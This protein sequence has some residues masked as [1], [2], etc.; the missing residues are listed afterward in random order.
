MT[1]E[2]K[3]IP[4]EVIVMIVCR[5]PK[6]K[7]LQNFAMACKTHKLVLTSKA[8]NTLYYESFW[9]PLGVSRFNNQRFSLGALFM[10]SG[11][12][13]YC[14]ACCTKGDLRVQLFGHWR[15]PDEFVCRECEKKVSRYMTVPAECL[16]IGQRRGRRQVFKVTPAQL[17]ELPKVWL[18]KPLRNNDPLVDIGWFSV[19][20]HDLKLIA[21]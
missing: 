10:L 20:L 17:Q 1:A 19:S 16:F 2:W 3:D 5:I 15:F 9:R 8:F 7:D 21:A 12:K 13:G 14:V 4:L 18:G 11:T 6:P